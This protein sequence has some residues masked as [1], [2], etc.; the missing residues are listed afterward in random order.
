MSQKKREHSCHAAGCNLE[1]PPRHLMCMNHWRMV[2]KALQD[3][4]WKHYRAGQER[5]KRPSREYLIAMRNA[6]EAVAI[7]EESARRK[8]QL[9][10]RAF[11]GGYLFP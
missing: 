11:L 1:I 9:D 8:K 3:E 6:I 2:P 7:K 5:D 4:I 10:T